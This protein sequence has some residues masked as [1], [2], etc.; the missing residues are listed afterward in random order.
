MD[1]MVEFTDEATVDRLCA[2]GKL[3]FRSSLVP[4]LALEAD[5][6]QQIADVPGVKQV[7]PAREV[8]WCGDGSWMTKETHQYKLKAMRELLP[9]AEAD[10]ARLRERCA[11]TPPPKYCRFSSLRRWK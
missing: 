4:W 10:L 8:V 11:D 5:S 6:E 9:R 2:I 3:V 7:Y 1:F